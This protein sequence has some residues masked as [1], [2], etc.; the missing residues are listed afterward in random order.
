MEDASQILCFEPR[1]TAAHLHSLSFRWTK[2]SCTLSHD[3]V[4]QREGFL[5]TYR[6]TKKGEEQRKWPLE[7]STSWK[8]VLC[9]DVLGGERENT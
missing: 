9:N 8:P 4:T 2:C 7:S 1:G 3:Q 5:F 6:M